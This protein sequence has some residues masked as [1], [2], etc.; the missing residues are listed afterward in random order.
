MASTSTTEDQLK[1]AFFSFLDMLNPASHYDAALTRRHRR[2]LRL[3]QPHINRPDDEKIMHN[4]PVSRLASQHSLSIIQSLGL[5]LS[6]AFGWHTAPTNDVDSHTSVGAAKGTATAWLFTLPSSLTT[7]VLSYCTVKDVLCRCALA[8]KELYRHI[9]LHGKAIF[10]AGHRVTL[11]SAQSM[12]FIEG[13]H[14]ITQV[15]FVR[16]RQHAFMQPPVCCTKSCLCTTS[17]NTMRM[18]TM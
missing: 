4:D 2:V 15:R 16:R 12:H 11:N 17:F 3:S 14:D 10:H 1:S 5:R 7:Q 18:F 9:N 13:C 8:N 6:T